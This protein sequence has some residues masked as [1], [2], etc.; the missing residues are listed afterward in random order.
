MQYLS[1]AFATIA[2][3]GIATSTPVLLTPSTENQALGIDPIPPKFGADNSASNRYNPPNTD[4][5]AYENNNIDTTYSIYRS[6]L[7]I[8]ATSVQNGTSFQ[9]TTTISYSQAAFTTAQT[10]MTAFR[11]A[12][13]PTP[14]ACAALKLNPALDQE[15][16]AKYVAFVQHTADI[17]YEHSIDGDGQSAYWDFC[18]IDDYMAAVSSYIQSEGA[19]DGK[20]VGSY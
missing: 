4:K 15:T 14:T 2:F 9:R 1:I 18:L 12:A 7:Q 8:L 13:N 16:A 11:T 3:L 5:A 10:S 19:Y 17:A 20:S 6:S